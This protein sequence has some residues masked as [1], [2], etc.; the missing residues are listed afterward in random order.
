[1]SGKIG[2]VIKKTFPRVYAW[3]VRHHKRRVDKIARK[4]LRRN[5]ARKLGKAGGELGEVARYI[6]KHGI[7]VFPYPYRTKYK[8][9]DIEVF[10]DDECGLLYL[11]HEGRR[12]YF[13]RGTTVNGAQ[14]Y[15]SGLLME[16]D[17]QSPHLYVHDNFGMD[18]GSVLLDIGSAEGNFALSNIE[19]LSKLFIF[20]ASPEWIEP[21]EHTF[22]PWRDK[23]E[24]INKFVSD[25]DSADTVTIDTIV[26]SYGLSA[27][28]FVKM[29]VEGAEKDVIKGAEKT[30]AEYPAPIK[31]VVCTYHRAGDYEL[32]SGMMTQ[33]GFDVETSPGYMLFI[34]DPNGVKEY[35]Y[36]RRGVIYCTKTK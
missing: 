25:S 9:E 2:E 24:I 13:R 16:Q 34:Y 19:K 3:A 7:M 15:Y 31:A 26:A 30:F 1:M 35:P 12:L 21:L 14:N 28:V 27:P 8:S 32:L 36:F 5:I 4:R 17:E 33:R 18:E 22:A 20:E 10:T 6:K 29:D 11:L 23:V